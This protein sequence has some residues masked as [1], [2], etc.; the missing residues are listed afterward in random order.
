M[1]LTVSMLRFIDS[2]A[3]LDTAIK[4]LLPLAQAPV[5][6]YPELV[7]SGTVAL[8]IGLMSHENAD[9]VI[10]VVEVLHELTDE[11]VGNEAE[12]EGEREST[13]AALKL[14]IEALVRYA[15]VHRRVTL[16][17]C[18]AREFHVGSTGLKFDPSE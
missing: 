16:I 11:D 10:D 8:L 7:R 3:D 2:E 12:E 4:Q 5:L 15:G 6:A 9:I 18:Q 14:L 17:P 1:L 13:L